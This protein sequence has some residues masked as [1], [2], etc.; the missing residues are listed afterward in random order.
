MLPSTADG[1]QRYNPTQNQLLSISEGKTQVFNAHYDAEGV[2]FYQ[3]LCP[4][5]A[6]YLLAHGEY[7]GARWSWKRTS[8]IKPS[9]SWMLYRAKYGRKPGQERIVRIKLSHDTVGLILSRCRLQRSSKTAKTSNGGLEGKRS[10]AIV[11]WDPERDLYR[12]GDK[13]EWK[14][15]GALSKTRAIQIGCQPEMFGTQ[16]HILEVKDMTSLALQVAYAHGCDQ[17]KKGKWAKWKEAVVRAKME[18]LRPVLP[19]EQAYLPTCSPADLQR[20]GLLLGNNA[21]ELSKMGNGRNRNS[22]AAR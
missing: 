18:L 1:K 6:D 22:T 19:V 2:Y 14:L 3:A 9:F 20:L 5:S 17:G 21:S 8:W 11:Q 7:G 10:G 13:T 4:E 16:E 15:P 12:S